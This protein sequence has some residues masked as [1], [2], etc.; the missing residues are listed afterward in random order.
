M[1]RPPYKPYGRLFTSSKHSYF[2]SRQFFKLEDCFC[3]DLVYETV[4]L[5]NRSKYE[6][7]VSKRTIV[8]DCSVYVV[9]SVF[10]SSFRRRLQ[11]IIVYVRKTGG[12]K[13]VMA[14]AVRSAQQGRPPRQYC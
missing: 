8:V 11:V 9:S 12:R 1:Q 5:S 7:S 4:F 2:F 14:D 10:D 6:G 3:H 13:A